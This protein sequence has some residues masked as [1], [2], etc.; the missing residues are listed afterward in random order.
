MRSL[1]CVLLVLLCCCTGIFKAGASGGEDKYPSFRATGVRVDGSLKDWPE[2]VLHCNYEAKVFYA[3]GNDSTY[4]YIAFQIMDFSEQR[5][6]QR[7]GLLVWF[8]PS[9]K[10]KKDCSILFSIGPPMQGQAPGAPPHGKTG[11][12]PPDQYRTLNPLIP[13]K[14]SAAMKCKGFAQPYNGDLAGGGLDSEMEGIFATDSAGGLVLEARIPLK[15]FLQDPRKSPCMAVGSEISEMEPPKG[16]EP[17]GMPDGG[18]GSDRMGGGNMGP[19]GRPGEGPGGEPGKGSPA[20]GPG[21][22]GQ[23][24]AKSYKIW[25]R[26][27]ILTTP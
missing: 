7:D 16:D 10:K 13:R 4:L 11:N 24:Q 25:Y 26:F 20:G 12:P 8:D 9:G 1:G 2:P 18:M 19:G 15:A 17:D 22:P 27:T 23:N 6:I 14:A 5:R 3:A 21:G